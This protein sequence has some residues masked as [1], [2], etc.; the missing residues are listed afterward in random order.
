MLIHNE[1][2]LLENLK[3]C[4]GVEKCHEMFI[5]SFHDGRSKFKRITLV[6]DPVC[7]KSQENWMNISEV[8][9]DISLQEF[10]S[11]HKVTEREA[12]LIFYEIVK[13]VSLFSKALANFTLKPLPL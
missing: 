2:L 1:Y 8:V 13:V 9:A 4:K 5:D 7:D 12:L 3:G 6:L 11:R 10:I